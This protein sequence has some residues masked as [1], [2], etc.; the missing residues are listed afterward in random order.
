MADG[1]DR[2]VVE[3]LPVLARYARVL[4]RD[5]H[6]SEDLL[7]DALL[8]AYERSATFRPDGS[9][10]AWLLSIIHNVFISRIRRERVAAE[11]IG[12]LA[13]LT[14]ESMPPSQETTAYFS[15]IARRFDALPEGQRA[16]LSLIAVEGMS[17]REAADALGVPVGTVMS[18]LARARASL[19]DSTV[20][21]NRPGLKIVGKQD[22]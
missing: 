4:T 17:Y 12:R 13:A 16:A 5:E 20:N 19:R 14:V 15:E 8:R 22:G 1:T 11:S 2:D 6:A 21:T 9:L 3:L 7:H 18:R 10:R